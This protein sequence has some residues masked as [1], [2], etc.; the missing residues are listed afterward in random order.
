MDALWEFVTS[1]TFI[2]I[3]VSLLVVLIGVFVLLRVMKKDED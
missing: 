3:L 2:I 1:W